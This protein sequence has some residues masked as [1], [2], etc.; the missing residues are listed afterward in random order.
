MC[1]FYCPLLRTQRVYIYEWVFV[2][3]SF[4]FLFFLYFEILFFLDFSILFFSDQKLPFLHCGEK[5]SSFFSYRLPRLHLHRSRVSE[6][7]RQVGVEVGF[8]GGRRENLGFF[9]VFSCSKFN[10]ESIAL[11]RIS[12]SLLQ[13]FSQGPPMQQLMYNIYLCGETKKKSRVSSSIIAPVMVRR[14]LLDMC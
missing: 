10:P 1:V 5:N 9:L 4:F 7:I 8:R 14:L 3:V 11:F 2:H 13:Q 6:G 12:I